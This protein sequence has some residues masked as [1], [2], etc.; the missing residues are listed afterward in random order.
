VRAI[1]AIRAVR[2]VGIGLA[3][4]QELTDTGFGAPVGAEGACCHVDV[5]CIQ[6]A[7][8]E[9]HRR[10]G[11]VQVLHQYPDVHEHQPVGQPFVS[12]GQPPETRRHADQ[13]L[14][15]AV[16]SRGHGGSAQQ[17]VSRRA[18]RADRFEPVPE[19][20]VVVYAIGETRAAADRE[21]KLELVAGASAG[22]RAT[23]VRRAS[24]GYVGRVL[25]AWGG[26]DQR[27]DPG[28]PVQEIAK[29]RRGYRA[30]R[31]A[32]YR[33]AHLHGDHHRRVTPVQVFPA[34]RVQR[35]VPARLRLDDRFD[36]AGRPGRVGDAEIVIMPPES[37]ADMKHHLNWRPAD[38]GGVQV[39][40]KDGGV[41][42]SLGAHD[43]ARGGEIF[44]YPRGG[45]LSE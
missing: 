43:H 26:G 33:A 15:G 11:Y 10:A 12:P 2:A 20:V 36:R 8:R 32:A 35:Y 37:A 23:A 40:R 24:G 1:R 38:D 22:I 41:A 27:A 34:W 18:I 9:P 13:Y 19:R 7:G 21:V 14:C 29:L 5:H 45:R 25:P 4:H 39:F 6:G 44:K 17:F 31:I 42:R 30:L 28:R 16:K 3:A